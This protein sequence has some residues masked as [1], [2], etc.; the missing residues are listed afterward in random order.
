[1]TRKTRIRLAIASIAASMIA[2]A[3]IPGCARPQDP[4]DRFFAAEGREQVTPVF[5][6]QAARGARHDGTLYAHHF[7]GGNLNSLGR[8]KLD[9]MLRDAG[10]E[11]PLVVHLDL[12]DADALTGDRRAAAREHLELSGLKDDQFRFEAG[13]NPA[14]LHPASPAITGLNRMD[15][16]AVKGQ[17]PDSDKS[18][19]GFS[20]AGGVGDGTR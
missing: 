8:D 11:L 3:F 1:M 19:S 10:Q 9:L 17:G 12:R 5:E 7:D 14:T 20:P 15:E 16:A 6:A 4:M 13:A 2:A 18:P